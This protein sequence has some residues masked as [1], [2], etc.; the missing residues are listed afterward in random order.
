MSGELSGKRVLVTG[1]S[2][3]IGRA[4]VLELARRGANVAF[5]FKGSAEAAE[6]VRAEAEALGVTAVALQSDVAV[7][8]AAKKL[9]D[10][11]KAA[12]GGIDV[13]VNNAG[14][15][16]DKLIMQMNE[17]DWDDVIDT[18]LKGVFNVTKHAA[19]VM[20]KQRKGRVVNI[21]SISG[22][23]GF[24]GQTNYAASKAALAGF[25]KSL[26]N[27]LGRRNVSAVTL[28]L[29]FVETEMTA[30]LPEEYVAKMVERVALRRPAKADEIARIVATFC[31][32][33]MEYVN[34]QT[35]VV[36]GGG[37]L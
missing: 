35:I 3:G 29:G 7:F 20:V 30:T 16:R 27:E 13:L 25:T 2:R 19:A 1:G 33:E 10:D 31:S 8:E 4:T 9:V 26:A 28:A 32:D 5:T 15:V 21:G 37:S 18:N 17:A 11:A 24:V 34:G 22:I 36:D 23:A 12:L 14:I 6:A